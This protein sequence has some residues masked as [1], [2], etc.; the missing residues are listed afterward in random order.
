MYDLYL[1]Y[2]SLH[3]LSKLLMH[4]FHTISSPI[5][6]CGIPKTKHDLVLGH[7]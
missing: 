6:V 1:S 3:D 4:V 2:I 7:E 5:E